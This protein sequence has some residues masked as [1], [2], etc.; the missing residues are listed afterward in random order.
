MNAIFEE[1]SKVNVN[2]HTEKKNGL[3]YL[4]WAWAWSELKK[5][6]PSASYSIKWFDGKPYYQDPTG[7]MV[8]TE[9]TVDGMSHEMWLPVMDANN[10]PILDHPYKYLTKGRWNADTKQYEKVEHLVSPATMFDINKTIMR[11]LAKNI[12]IFGLGLYI[13]GGEDLPKEE[14][15]EADQQAKPSDA[16]R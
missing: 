15:N 8:F 3:T 6:Y 16:V 2:D 13:Y 12:A 11:C 1:L 9:I 14:K 7:Y 10:K 5:R 4:S